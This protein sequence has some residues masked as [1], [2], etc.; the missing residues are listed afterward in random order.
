MFSDQSRFSSVMSSMTNTCCVLLF[1]FCLKLRMR[2]T[3][4][5]SERRSLRGAEERRGRVCP[6]CG[7]TSAVAMDT[8]SSGGASSP[9]C[10]RT[11]GQKH[12]FIFLL[13]ITSVSRAVVQSTSSCFYCKNWSSVYIGLNNI[14]KVL[15]MSQQRNKSI[16]NNQ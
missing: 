9:S 13:Q 16:T 11:H 1:R 14:C 5:S 10:P 3:A 4:P 2:L 15:L 12:V 7:T 6:H 8:S